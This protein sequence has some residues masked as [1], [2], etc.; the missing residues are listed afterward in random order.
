MWRTRSLAGSDEAVTKSSETGKNIDFT[1]ASESPCAMGFSLTPPSINPKGLAN[2]RHLHPHP[3]YRRPHHPRAH[4]FAQHGYAFAL[5]DCRGRGNS[6]GE[7]ES[8]VNE[9]RDGSDVVEWLAA[10]PWCD[11]SV[12][13]W[14]GSYGGCDQWLTLK[15]FP[16]HLK[17]I[18]P[19]AAAH[20]GLDFPF[21]KNIFY[22]YNMQW[23]TFT[24]GRTPN[25]NLFQELGFWIEKFR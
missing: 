7:F 13:M 12:T 2:T 16:P 25:A 21:F 22:P 11:G 6:Q 8:G 19:A 20:W 4:Y 24:S 10:Q 9:G 17:T 23:L 3:L 18:V 5:V 14:G 1:W 15:E